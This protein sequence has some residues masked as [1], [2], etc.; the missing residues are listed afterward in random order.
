MHFVQFFREITPSFYR[1]KSGIFRC[2]SDAESHDVGQRGL[3]SFPHTL[4]SM[5]LK[6][7]CKV[8]R[9]KENI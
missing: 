7:I 9:G 3:K 1:S 8:L 5:E 6:I 4:I 2:F